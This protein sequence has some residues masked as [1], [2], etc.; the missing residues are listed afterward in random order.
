METNSPG[1]FVCPKWFSFTFS[2][3]GCFYW[4]STSRLTE[5]S[6]FQSFT[7]AAPLFPGHL[8]FYIN[9]PSSYCPFLCMMWH[10]SLY[11]FRI[12]SLSFQ[13]L[14]MICLGVDL[15]VFILLGVHCSYWICESK[16]NFWISYR[17]EVEN[18]VFKKEPELR[19][20]HH[21]KSLVY[22]I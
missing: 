12:F 7:D 11:T 6:F 1:F 17:N 8:C 18:K 16:I 5:F 4:T 20:A 22:S 13:H 15:F 19:W 14:T 21:M 3:E 9:C 10:F 2:F